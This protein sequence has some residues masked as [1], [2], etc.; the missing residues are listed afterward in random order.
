MNLNFERGNAES[1]KGHAFLYFTSDSSK[2][3]YFA[4][5][6]IIQPINVDVSKYVP[7]FLINQM[8]DIGSDDLSMFAFPPSPEQVEGMDDINSLAQT[9]EDDV[10]YG[11]QI[12]VKDPA[13]MIMTVNEILEQYANLYKETNRM[14]TETTSM[15]EVGTD[16]NEVI[17][18][19]MSDIDKL[20]ELTKLIGKLR[21]AADDAGGELS[22]ET[23]DQIRL[24]SKHL[25]ANHE[26]P[27]ILQA[28]KESDSKGQRLADLY[29]KRSFHLIN[30]SFADLGELEQEIKKLEETF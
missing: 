28:A 1:P 27:K 17:Y 14:L 30:E 11:G 10:I 23:E 5:Y 4:T 20:E 13:S 6:L 12:S 19:L 29:L 24:L 9:R 22:K 16:V 15:A 26:I 3:A 2:T 21:Y 18:S 7:P 8:G 25:P